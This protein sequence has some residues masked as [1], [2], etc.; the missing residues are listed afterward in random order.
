MKK[1]LKQVLAT[2]VGISLWFLLAI[3]I[4]I[5]SVICMSIGDSSTTAVKNGS[6]MRITLNGVLSERSQEADV[7]SLLMGGNTEGLG[8]DQLLAG[9]DAAAKNDKVEG[10]YLEVGAFDGGTPAM[11]QE[12]RQALLKY[13][14]DSGKWIIAYGDIYTQGAYYL[15]SVADK[16][17]L[18]PEGMVDWHGLAS[19]PM[20]YTDLLKKV[21]V[22][23]QV[24]KVGKF[25]SAVEPYIATE[26]SEPN[27]QQVTSF[28]S[29]IWEQMVEEV[30]ESRSLTAEQLNLMADTF[31][32]MQ[33]SQMLVDYHMVDTLTYIDGVR[34]F[35]RNRLNLE[36]GK[37]IRFV[38]P[39]DVVAD[40]DTDS[41]DDKIAVF[42]AS[43]EIVQQ[44]A[45]SIASSE[46]NI[47]QDEVVRELRK[48]RENED[49][50]A[51]VMRVNS[52]GGSAFA[53]EQ[54][55]REL[56]LLKEQKPVVVSMGGMAAS[57]GYYISCGAS[58]IFAEPTTLTGSIG[59]FGLIP[60]ASELLTEKLELHFDVVA[61]NR[62]SDFGAMGRPFNAEEAALMQAYVERG[63]DLF[64]RRV[65]EG[66]G[67]PQD[68]VDAIGQG[69]VWT[70]EQAIQLGLVDQ[71]GNLEDALA[72]A[73]KL[74]NL[75]EYERVNYPEQISWIDR[76]MQDK[77]ESYFD[78]RL[79]EALG[80]L[81]PMVSTLQ[82]LQYQ[83][84][85]QQC[86]FTRL[87]FELNIR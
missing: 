48:L 21:G 32:T 56:Q 23:F 63:Y 68:S 19:Q 51:V 13:K 47:V 30:G 24:F 1:F 69:R 20:F 7:M 25:K 70:G 41:H 50:K 5:V 6:V 87:P 80:N 39:A 71:L 37:S 38:S 28:L 67:L 83:R 84:V 73:A 49:I 10:I 31:I 33:P 82:M 55:W 12:L 61:T 46:E 77:P 8:L 40:A 86:V 27:R 22:K 2:V 42:Y 14:Q 15:C 34:T 4:C 78:A 52:P 81:Y 65:A 45:N 75:T 74:A 11:L 16:V 62:H 79:H 57:G 29:S 76:M 54:I 9:I 44:V 35:L 60:D 18:N 36:E 72:E 43:G 85:P 58:K 66:R 53:S 59:I 64:T 26:M 3:V 17:M